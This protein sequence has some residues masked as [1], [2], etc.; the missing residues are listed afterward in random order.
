MGELL[1][2]GIAGDPFL[3]DY[4]GLLLETTNNGKIKSLLRHAFV[5]LIKLKFQN[6]FL[7]VLGN[8][9]GI[10]ERIHRAVVN[11]L[12]RFPIHLHILQQY[13]N[14]A[15]SVILKKS[16][17]TPGSTD[18]SSGDLG[19]LFEQFLSHRNSSLKSAN[20]IGELRKLAE[21]SLLR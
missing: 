11:L 20:L 14:R 15:S 9:P 21:S 19:P 2:C 16:Q 5:G 7:K 8:E 12:S 3:L 6:L 17:P 1:S 4:L 10:D 13:R 18:K